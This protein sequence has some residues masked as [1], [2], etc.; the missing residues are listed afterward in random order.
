MSATIN[1]AG[2]GVTL[3]A[4][5][6]VLVAAGTGY[7]PTD[8]IAL[9]DGA[10]T[11]NGALTVTATQVV[12]ATI[13]AAGS[14]GTTGAATISS[15]AAAGTV[16]VPGDTIT[17]NDSAAVTHGVIKVSTT[18]VVSATIAAAGT[19]TGSTGDIYSIR[20]YR[21][22]NKISSILYSNTW[23]RNHCSSVYYCSWSYTVN[24]TTLATEPV[25]AANLSGAKLDVVMGVATA[26]ITT[27]GAV[28][29]T[30]SNPVAQ[31]SSSGSGTGATFNLTYSPPR[32]QEQQEPELSSRQRAFWL[33]AP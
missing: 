25:Y 14:S 19:F 31:T 15:I 22:R 5:A 4:T 9:S 23:V 8:V 13:N 21:N 20:N 7:V 24:P 10:A 16:Y 29:S 30:P 6:A 18:G 27:A 1:A 11:T 28:A 33:A 2:S 12:T 26:A 17:L 3:G 32:L